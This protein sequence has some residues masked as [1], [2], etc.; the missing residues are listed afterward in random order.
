[1]RTGG[2]TMTSETSTCNGMNI[3]PGIGLLPPS[4]ENSTN[5][6]PSKLSSTVNPIYKYSINLIVKQHMLSSDSMLPKLYIC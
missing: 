2:T 6:I 1:M 5:P 3:F 4:A